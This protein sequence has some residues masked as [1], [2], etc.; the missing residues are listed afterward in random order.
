MRWTL[1]AL[2]AGTHSRK[3]FNKNVYFNT[4]IYTYHDK[5]EFIVCSAIN[6]FIAKFVYVVY[7]YHFSVSLH[8]FSA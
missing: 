4:N 8:N 6:L 7:P 1:W 3:N 5:I 2:I